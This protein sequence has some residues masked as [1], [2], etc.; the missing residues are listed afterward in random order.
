MI[1]KK[2]LLFCKVFFRCDKRPDL[3]KSNQLAPVIPVYS[4]VGDRK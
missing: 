2:T 3:L 1:K 4:T